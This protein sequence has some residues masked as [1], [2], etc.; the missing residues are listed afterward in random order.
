MV[1]EELGRKLSENIPIF[2]FIGDSNWIY[3]A[4]IDAWQVIDATGGDLKREVMLLI[5]F[6]RNRDGF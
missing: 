1:D 5:F 4:W 2:S 6:Y 3:V